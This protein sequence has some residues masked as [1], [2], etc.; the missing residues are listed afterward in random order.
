MHTISVIKYPSGKYGF[1]GSLPL[2]LTK[3]ITDQMGKPMQV[4][5]I[6]DTEEQADLV[7]AGYLTI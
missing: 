2:E 3:T 5:K 7:L 6:F 1:V 4:S